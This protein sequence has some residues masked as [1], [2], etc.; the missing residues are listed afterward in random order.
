MYSHWILSVMWLGLRYFASTIPFIGP[1]FGFVQ[2]LLASRGALY[3]EGPLSKTGQTVVKMKLKWSQS[4][5]MSALYPHFNLSLTLAAVYSVFALCTTPIRSL[6]S[7]YPGLSTLYHHFI[8]SYG[9]SP[10]YECDDCDPLTEWRMKLRC[11][12]VNWLIAQRLTLLPLF[13]GLQMVT[14]SD[15]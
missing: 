5:D 12:R 7:L 13:A 8:H 6:A 2:F 1:R 15:S 11:V 3:P 10:M 9:L 4:A 14:Q